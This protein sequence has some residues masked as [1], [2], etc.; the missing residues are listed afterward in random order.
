MRR[1]D[2]RL[3]RLEERVPVGCVGCRFWGPVV[4]E[5]GDGTPDRPERCPGCGRVV[6]VRLVRRIVL[7]PLGG[8]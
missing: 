5:D 3:R 1:A 2:V 4:Y 7:V 8:P 6:E